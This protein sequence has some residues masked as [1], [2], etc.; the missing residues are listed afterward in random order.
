MPRP[1][2]AT[3]FERHRGRPCSKWQHYFAAYD[4]EFGPYRGRTV[5]MLEIG[6]A[7]GGSTELFRR[8]LGPRAV[9]LGIDINPRCKEY[10]AQGIRIEI[11]S[12]SDP[13]FLDRL[14]R[15]YGPFDIILDDGSHV[16]Q[17]QIAS[18][19]HLFAAVRPGGVY[20]VEDIHTSYFS[21]FGGGYRHAD[22]FVEHAKSMI[23]AQHMWWSHRMPRSEAED[24]SPW[25]S[26]ISFYPGMVFFHKNS[27]APPRPIHSENGSQREDPPRHLAFDRQDDPS[28]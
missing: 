14:A 8:F 15:E 18:L 26:R 27:V 9:V 23:D 7:R 16:M 4:R 25:L 17:D 21:R 22:S 24:W 6:V 12:Q 13:A 19:A 2:F 5:R 1:S 28:G 20:A 10:E 11:G 3:L